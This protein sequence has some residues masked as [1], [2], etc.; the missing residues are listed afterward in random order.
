M[1]LQK[2]DEEGF[3]ATGSFELAEGKDVWTHPVICK[4]RL[5]LRYHDTMYCYDIRQ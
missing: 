1:T 4:G 3:T 2:F 5:F